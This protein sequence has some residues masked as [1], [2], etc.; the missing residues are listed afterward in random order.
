MIPDLGA[1]IGNEALHDAMAD[2]LPRAFAAP[3]G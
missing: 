3:P 2:M 1:H